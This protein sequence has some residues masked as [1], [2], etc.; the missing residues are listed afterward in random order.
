MGPRAASI[1]LLML[2]SGNS[3][4]LVAAQDARDP[5][6]RLPDP[7][8]VPL[9]QSVWGKPGRMNITPQEGRYLH[10]LIIENDLKACL[11][12]GTSNGYSALWLAMALRQTGGRLITL[13]NNS[14]RGR[15]AMANFKEA[16]LLDRIDLRVEDALE[17]IPTLPGPF[18]FIFIDAWKEDY[19][20][21]LEMVLP[22][23]RPGGIIV[24]HN[25]TDGRSAMAGFIKEITHDPLL[26]T[27]FVPISR[28]GLS[29]SRKIK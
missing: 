6:S 23:V 27:E 15:E 28:S 14:A 24:A 13:E 16:G 3:C 7:T 10:D 21:Y 26:E 29:V 20:R 5:H 2:F 11:E 25:V 8:L 9:L 1:L 22:K 4:A 18:D 12:V 17:I 19:Q